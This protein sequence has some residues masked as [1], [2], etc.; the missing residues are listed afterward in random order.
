[1]NE[2]SFV[3]SHKP[4]ERHFCDD[5]EMAWA[6][7]R[8]GWPD[9]TIV[10]CEDCGDELYFLSNRGDGY[11]TDIKWHNRWLVYRRAGLR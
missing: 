8:E 10:Q 6:G 3:V 4:V 11:M 7:N 1:M 5:K 2:R 9:Y